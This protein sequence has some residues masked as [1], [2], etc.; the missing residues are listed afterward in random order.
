MAPRNNTAS[1]LHS[2][3]EELGCAPELVGV[4]KKELKLRKRDDIK[5]A[6]QERMTQQAD[7][8]DESTSAT[9]GDDAPKP[10]KEKKAGLTL[11][12]RRALLRLLDAAEDGIVPTTGFKALPFEKLE[13]VG[14]AMSQ[15]VESE[16]GELRRFTLT[17]SGTARAVEINPG[18]RDW[19][20]GETVAGD[21]SRPVA[22]TWRAEKARV[23][24]EKAAAEAEVDDSEE[25]SDETETEPVAIE[26]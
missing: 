18:Y 21:E 9:G 11:S 23:E 25:S 19:S 26:A 3:A 24:A 5:H 22:G 20:A 1:M 16:D 17:T 12:Q 4:V 6:V 10:K 14:Y 13:S 15:E 8:T 2:I 7:A